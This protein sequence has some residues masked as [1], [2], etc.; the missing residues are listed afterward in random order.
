VSA[1]ETLGDRNCIFG[2]SEFQN[3]QDQL[4]PQDLVSCVTESYGCEGGY[5]DSAWSYM[6]SPGIA[7]CTEACTSGCHPYTSYNCS[8][9]NPNAQD[10]CAQ[11]NTVSCVNGNEFL[12]YQAGTYDLI[13]PHDS[14]DQ[15]QAIQLE[16]STNGPVQV[17]F[18]VYDNFF[19]FFGN[20]P[21]GIY[22]Q[23]SG[24]VAGGHC[25]KLIGWGTDSVSGMN[26]WIIANSW[27]QWADNGF[28]KYI[29]GI[30]LAGMESS[31]MSGCPA[32]VANCDLTFPASAP[33]GLS[34]IEK[35][36]RGGWRKLESEQ[37]EYVQR[38]LML[39][40]EDLEKKLHSEVEITLTRGFVQVVAG[41][42]LKLQV[43]VLSGGVR[44]S[45]TIEAFYSPSLEVTIQKI[46]PLLKD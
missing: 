36:I 23:T 8:E 39:A 11:C 22:N 13:S 19:T 7:T 6:Q 46:S 15:V 27:G 4:T 42:N 5:E 18:T 28:F 1:A 3:T 43:S 40:T 2:L 20:W 24:S 35:P 10:G 17:C 21:T 34:H 16:V 45:S 31:S 32:N 12:T 41:L 37:S 38:A 9:S 33:H 14:Y 44:H 29:S 30:D 26:Y 25:V